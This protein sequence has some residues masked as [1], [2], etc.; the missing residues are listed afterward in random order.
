MG[1]YGAPGVSHVD[2]VREA[3]DRGNSDGHHAENKARRVQTTVITSI[4]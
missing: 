2:G 4:R 1:S 3:G